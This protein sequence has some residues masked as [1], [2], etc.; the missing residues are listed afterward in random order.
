MKE[1]VLLEP[2]G[3]ARRKIYQA[4]LKVFA[5]NG[6]SDISVSELAEAAGIARGTIY[7]NIDEPERLFAK[8]SGALSHE[9]IKRTEAT[10]AGIQ[11]PARRIA[12]GMRLFVRRAHEEQDWGRFLVRFAFGQSA[13]EALLKEPPARDIREAIASKRFKVDAAY[14]PTLVSMLNGA[15]MAAMSGVINGDQTWRDAGSKAAE[16]FLRAGGLAAREAR[17]IAYAELPPLAPAPSQPT[18]RKKP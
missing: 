17:T 6:G 15:T 4:A 11:D 9:M 2:A 7:N 13:L 1:T 18:K 12:T 8:V 16:L 3:S 5:E 14:A 10:M